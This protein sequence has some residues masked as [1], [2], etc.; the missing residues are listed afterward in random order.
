MLT[1]EHKGSLRYFIGGGD[2]LAQVLQ[3]LS[4]LFLLFVH[5]C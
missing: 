5:A 1:G 3:Y 2:R 4:L